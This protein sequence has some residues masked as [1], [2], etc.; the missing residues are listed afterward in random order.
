[1]TS[2]SITVQVNTASGVRMGR[3]C[4]GGPGGAA[5]GGSSFLPGGGAPAGAR[6][7]WDGGCT[8]MPMAPDDRFCG[9]CGK[10]VHEITKW[11]P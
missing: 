9:G 8:G 7:C 6:H 2:T 10:Q 1:M 11:A 5:A 4:P 3:P